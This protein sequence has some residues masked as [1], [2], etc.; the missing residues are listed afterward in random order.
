MNGTQQSR[1]QGRADDF[2]SSGF[3]AGAT[4]GTC[5][6]PLATAPGITQRRY[7][8]AKAELALWHRVIEDAVWRAARLGAGLPTDA[9]QAN[10]PRRVELMQ[11]E[12]AELKAWASEDFLFSLSWLCERLTAAIGQTFVPE[13]VQKQIFEALDAIRPA[14]RRRHQQASNRVRRGVSIVPVAA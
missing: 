4:E 1:R 5:W 14:F 7:V 11:A 12:V 2:G 3:A 10:S 9:P 8:V 13:P 6:A